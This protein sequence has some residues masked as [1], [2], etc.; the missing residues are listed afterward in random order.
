MD[1]Q[2][3]DS[4]GVKENSIKQTNQHND[5]TEIFASRISPRFMWISS[6]EFRVKGEQQDEKVF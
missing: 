4:L 1:L 6:Q 3:V 5:Q 2:Q